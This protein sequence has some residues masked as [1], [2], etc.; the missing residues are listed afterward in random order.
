MKRI[1]N[2]MIE[3]MTKQNLAMVKEM[4]DLSDRL[5]KSLTYDY[6]KSIYMMDGTIQIDGEWGHDTCDYYGEFRGGYSWIHPTLEKIA[7]KH[8]YGIEWEN[9][10]CCRLF[11]IY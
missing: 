1:L 2:E 7:D 11:K 5:R 9:P 6:S 4:G 8:G 3:A 10:A